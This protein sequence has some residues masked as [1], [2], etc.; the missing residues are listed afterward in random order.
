MSG[1]VSSKFLVEGT[2]PVPSIIIFLYL[3][4]YK[5]KIGSAKESNYHRTV[6]SRHRCLLRTTLSK[7]QT[8]VTDRWMLQATM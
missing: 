3:L 6:I 4:I 5:K 2:V 1:R 8:I 7:L